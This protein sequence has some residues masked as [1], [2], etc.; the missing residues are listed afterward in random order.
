[1]IRECEDEMI[2]RS[3]TNVSAAGRLQPSEMPA[4]DA[5]EPSSELRQQLLSALKQWSSP[6]F[7]PE[8]IN[9]T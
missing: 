1:M 4:N 7:V 8:V 5:L 3:E 6:A 2:K 9:C